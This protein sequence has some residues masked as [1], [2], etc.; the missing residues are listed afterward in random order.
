MKTTG[1]LVSNR[2]IYTRKCLLSSI[3]KMRDDV[4]VTESVQLS[5]F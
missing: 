2:G 1:E 4:K 5:L 3:E